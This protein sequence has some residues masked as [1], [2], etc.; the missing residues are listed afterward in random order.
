MTVCNAFALREA[1]EV[2]SQPPPFG[3]YAPTKSG[4]CGSDLPNSQKAPVFKKKRR[5]FLM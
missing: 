4:F 2:I 1:S 5:K 3:G